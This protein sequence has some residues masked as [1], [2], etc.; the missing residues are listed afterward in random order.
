MTL[1]YRQ[2][3]QSDLRVSAIGLGC[4]TFG[5]EIDAATAFDVLDH[6]VARGI[7][8]FDTA[9]AYGD[10]ASEEIIGRWLRAR[11]PQRPPVVATKVSGR[12][13]RENVLRSAADSLRRLGVE[14]IDLLQAHDWDAE[15]PCVQTLE[16][17]EELAGE[18]VI[19]YAGCSNWSAEQLS[20]ALQSAEQRA[21]RP[22]QTVQPMYNLVQ[23]DIER[24]LLPLCAQRKLGVITYSPLGAGFLTGKYRQDAP[25]PAGTRFDIKPG[26]Q[27][28]YFTPQQFCAV[29]GLRQI[30]AET[31]CSMARLA[32]G[33]LF[34]RPHVTSVLIGARCRAHIDQAFQA[35]ENPMDRAAI[36]RVDALAAAQ[37]ATS[38]DLAR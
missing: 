25:P 34:Q 3:G 27:R 28:I 17:F 32:L 4:V 8:L 20:Q 19:R 11:R 9:A 18:G 14:R 33:W 7:S 16:A 1:E 13:T 29:E 35:L 36:A 10:G 23:R 6:A 12:L 30:A 15:T 37:G 31:G 38:H 26:H 21:W 24:A 2:L 22:M 5:R